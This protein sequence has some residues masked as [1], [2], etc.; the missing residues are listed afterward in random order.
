MSQVRYTR[1]DAA[2]PVGGRTFDADLNFLSR[3][4]GPLSPLARAMLATF[5]SSRALEDRGVAARR[6]WLYAHGLTGLLPLGTPTELGGGLLVLWLED[7]LGAIALFGFFRRPR[8]SSTPRSGPGEKTSPWQALPYAGT[9]G[10]GARS[11]DA[12]RGRAG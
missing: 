11:L 4:A 7:A 3:W 8:R 6:R 2:P 10:P 1:A 12:W 9:R 5:S